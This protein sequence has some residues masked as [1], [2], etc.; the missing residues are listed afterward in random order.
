MVLSV[1]CDETTVLRFLAKKGVVSDGF[2]VVLEDTPR[3]LPRC[4]TAPPP[5]LW[6]PMWIFITSVPLFTSRRK[7]FRAPLPLCMR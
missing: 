4:P 6:G 2:E 7:C 3:P 5:S 1:L